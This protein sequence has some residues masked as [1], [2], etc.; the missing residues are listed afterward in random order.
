MKGIPTEL[1]GDDIASKLSN[2]TQKFDTAAQNIIQ[3]SA[4]NRHLINMTF[5]A[6]FIITIVTISLNLVFVIAMSVFGVLRFVVL[7]WL[8]TVIC[9]ILFGVCLFLEKFS[10]DACNALYNFQ[11]N[12]YNNSLSS[13]IPC[14]ELLSAKPVVAEVSSGIYNIVNEVLRPYTCFGDEDEICGNG[15]F[16][17][18]SEYEVIKE[19]TTSVQNLLNVFPGIDS[20]LECQLVKDAF[21]QVLQK[22]CKP[23]K[24]FGKVTWAAM[25]SLAATMVLLVV[26]WTLKANYHEHS[27]HQP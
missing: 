6:L 10:D 17:P 13:M 8:L 14:D 7:S 21:S 23:L 24:R 26:L 20:L 4:K 19:Y 27:N 22:H 16:I 1:M 15:K 25:V 11:E 2:T 5:K 3:E 18:G 9:W 12:P